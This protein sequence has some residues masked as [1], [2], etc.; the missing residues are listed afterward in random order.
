M[1]NR[2]TEFPRPTGRTIRNVLG[3]FGRV[4]Y[5]T[6][7]D[8][9]PRRVFEFFDDFNQKSGGTLPAPWNKQDTSAA[10]SPTLDYVTDAPGG[11]YVLQLAADNEV[12]AIGLNWNDH[13]PLRA[14]PDD[15]AGTALAAYLEFEA[16]WKLESDPTGAGGTI[17]ASGIV[18]IGIASARNATLT[19]IATRAMFRMAGAN[20]NLYLDTDDGTNDASQPDSGFDWAE[21]TWYTGRILVPISTV[22]VDRDSLGVRFYIRKDSDTDWTLLNKYSTTRQM[23]FDALA[24]SAK[25]QPFIE[26][27]KGAVAN[28]DNKLTV[29]Y[30]HTRFLRVSSL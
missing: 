11:A 1:A 14:A 3:P 13:M 25:F 24:N 8:R 6:E 16:R 4:D 20:H 26:L 21:A 23:K 12:E 15:S 19:S 22:A 7:V 5:A 29:D 27:Q 28:L 18:A 10:G 2:P 30:V 9:A 17:G